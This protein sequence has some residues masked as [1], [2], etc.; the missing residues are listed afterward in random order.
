VIVIN[1]TGSGSAT[2]EVNGQTYTARLD[3]AAKRWV[4]ATPQGDRT[5]SSPKLHSIGKLWGQPVT[6]NGGAPKAPRAPGVPRPPRQ[7]RAPRFGRRARGAGWG[8]AA[9][10]GPAFTAPKPDRRQ[11]LLVALASLEDAFVVKLSETGISPEVRKSYDR[12]QKLKAMALAPT[13]T[14]NSTTQTEAYAALRMS[15]IEMLKLSF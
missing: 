5:T 8:Q 1:K 9:K 11:L 2:V 15:V 6:V 7:P 3:P 14:A 13:A 4:V 10:A 12:Y